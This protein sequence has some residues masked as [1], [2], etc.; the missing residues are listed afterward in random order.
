MNLESPTPAPINFCLAIKENKTR[1][2]EWSGMSGDARKAAKNWVRKAA[3]YGIEHYGFPANPNYE[4]PVE[5]KSQQHGPHEN[6]SFVLDHRMNVYSWYQ[7][8]LSEE[9][10]TIQR[11]SDVDNLGGFYRSINKHTIFQINDAQGEIDYRNTC[12]HIEHIWWNMSKAPMDFYRRLECNKPT[13]LKSIGNTSDVP[14]T[15]HSAY[16]TIQ[17]RREEI[18]EDERQYEKGK[19]R[20]V[21]PAATQSTPAAMQST[22]GK[23]GKGKQRGKSKDKRSSSTSQRDV[24]GGRKGW[25][26]TKGRFWKGSYSYSSHW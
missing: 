17:D 23:K 18:E 2:G 15:R 11:T 5:G 12:D 1:R 9:A 19:G 3:E 21:V 25:D 24:K 22:K 10:G 20:N 7:A 14:K 4:P 6:L 26:K 8:M 13:V 16:D